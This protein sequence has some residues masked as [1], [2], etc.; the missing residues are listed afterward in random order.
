MIYKKVRKSAKSAQDAAS[1]SCCY[2]SPSRILIWSILTTFSIITNYTVTKTLLRT[3]L[4]D[5]EN[6]F[7][8]D[9]MMIVTINDEKGIDKGN[10]N[11]DKLHKEDHSKERLLVH[12]DTLTTNQE[13]KGYVV[14]VL[15]VASNTR[16]NYMETQRNTWAKHPLIRNFFNVTED[17]D[18]SMMMS[19]QQRM[20]TSL[21][22]AVPK[23]CR[24]RYLSIRSS[25]SQDFSWLMQRFVQFYAAKAWLMAKPN[26]AGWLCAQKRFPIGLATIVL[27]YVER[28]E[29]L[30]DYLLIVDDDTFYNMDVFY[31]VV[32]AS[33]NSS[34]HPFV[35]AGCRVTNGHSKEKGIVFP[36][37][38]FGLTFSKGSLERLLRPISI[39]NNL[40]EDVWQNSTLAAINNN[41][42]FERAV[43]EDGMNLA[44]MM[45]KFALGEPFH[46]TAAWTRGY[47]FH[48]HWLLA[49]FTQ[50][51]GLH[52]ETFMEAIQNSEITLRPT[53]PAP[54]YTNNCKNEYENCQPT[55]LACHYQTPLDMQRLVS[56]ETS[57]VSNKLNNTEDTTRPIIIL[58]S[59]FMQF[60]PNLT[61]LGRARLQLFETFCLPTILGQVDTDFLWILRTDPDLDRSLLDPLM[62]LL[63]PHQSRF[64]LIASND[65]TEGFRQLDVE[66]MDVLSGD[67][68]VLKRA[69]EDS[70]NRWVVEIRLD[71]DDGLHKELI[72]TVRGVATNYI[73]SEAP[74]LDWRALC[75]GR[76]INWHSG[77]L[78]PLAEIDPNVADT[79]N[80]PPE[81]ILT[82][83]TKRHLSCI[84]PGLSYILPPNVTS[85]PAIGHHVLHESIPACDESHETSGTTCLMMLDLPF[86][87]AVQART[88]TSHGMGG[89][90]KEYK[91]N[92]DSHK[93][94]SILSSSFNISKDRTTAV[95]D[96]FRQNILDIAKDN[97]AGQCTEDHSCARFSRKYLE[98]IIWN[99]EREV[100]QQVVEPW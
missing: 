85:P 78:A 97:L 64:F 65:N 10:K 84:T 51:Y 41:L 100:T 59:R 60:Q 35:G 19:C 31:N 4:Q 23:W 52:S 29:S 67:R 46:N 12:D 14:D 86:H 80:I 39:H 91:P 87:Q 40:A 99:K 36:F 98:R 18:G 74:S 43:F 30:P 68:D 5:M 61:A 15:S 96:D 49:I 89:F 8:P 9:D 28:G 50:L 33:Q 17:I 82:D 94:W 71:A 20:S 2:L 6:G 88:P 13:Y 27:G 58:K 83:P 66:S 37:G 54:L 21:V 76:S 92:R 55:D 22:S 48:G 75:V 1:V 45:K 3:T 42:I 93:L 79:R 81:G 77:A 38:G 62:N 90:H 32:I 69:V 34:D 57:T 70:R 63:E 16:L 73:L 47:C 11:S 7:L 24:K 56:G 26:P 53:D 72:G 95:I 25:D 44:E